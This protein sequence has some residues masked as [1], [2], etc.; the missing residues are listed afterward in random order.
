MF[1]S[2]LLCILLTL[3]N[4]YQKHE[5]AYHSLYTTRSDI[6][7]A[8]INVCP[9]PRISS[10]LSLGGSLYY[11][12]PSSLTVTSK[13]SPWST[14]L[15][16]LDAPIHLFYFSIFRPVSVHGSVFFSLSLL[17]HESGN[18]SSIFI[19]LE[20]STMACNVE[21]TDGWKIKKWMTIQSR[22]WK[23]S[24]ICPTICRL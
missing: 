2:R 7:F 21:W 13:R 14:R 9:S 24:L 8:F 18:F 5:P 11:L 17:D 20:P 3:L 23:C 15:I 19:S 4:L 1:K 10:S 22:K 12:H 6:N 16:P